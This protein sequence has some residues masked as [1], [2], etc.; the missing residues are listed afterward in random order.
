MDRARTIPTCWTRAHTRTLGGSALL[1]ALCACSGEASGPNNLIPNASCPAIGAA[2]PTTDASVTLDAS[3]RFQTVQ[4]FGT[5]QRLFDDP[6]VTD[7]FDPTTR[8]AAVIVPATEQAKIL[9]ALYVDLGLTRVRFHPDGMEPVN[10]NADPMSADLSKFDFSW[11]KSDGHIAQIRQ[12]VSRGVTTYFGSPIT[13]EPWMNETNPAEYAE[14]VIVMLR[15]WRDQGLEMPY[16]SLMNEPGYVRSGYW[17]GTWLRDVAK[18]LGARIKAEGLK[19]RLV[20]PDDV[21]PMEAYGRLQTI[22]AD[23]DARQYV[24]AVAYHLYDR[25]GEQQVKQLAEQYGIPIWMTE[26]STPD[27]WFAWATIMQ[28]LLADDGVS[29]IDYMWGFF[30]DWDKSQLVRIRVNN[31]TYAGYDFNRQY[32]VMGQYSRFVRPGAVRIASTSSDADVKVVSFVDAGK[33]VVVATNTGTRDHAVR[34]ELGSAPCTGVDAVRTSDNESWKALPAITM[35]S[36]RFAA[37]VPAR[38]VTTFVAR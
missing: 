15:H 19:T 10:D 7:T 27:D 8:R 2:L 37:T 20:V 14:W 35:D 12:L 6:H 4:G 22:L 33:V 23:P 1:L 16:Y 34:F 29:A 25:G 31:A 9:D 13:I 21:N 36:P 32:Y 26:F 18:I 24:G 17:S 28:Q 3:Q 11:Q 38:S 30:G 5:S